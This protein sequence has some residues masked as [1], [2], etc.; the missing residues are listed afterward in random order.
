M[1]DSD[2]AWNI[3]HVSLNLFS[4]L[5]LYNSVRLLS[6]VHPFRIRICNP[7]KELVQILAKHLQEAMEEVFLV[8]LVP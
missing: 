3:R 2:D 7:T 4:L 1:S 8:V 5:F 6:V